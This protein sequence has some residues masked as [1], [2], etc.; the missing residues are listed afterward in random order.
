MLGGVEG[1]DH[2]RLPRDVGGLVD[3][4]LGDRGLV[5][6]GLVDRS[7]G[8]GGCS[9]LR[10]GAHE[11]AQPL[12]ASRAGTLHRS[13]GSTG[14][15]AHRLHRGFRGT[16][17]ALGLGGGGLWRLG[18]LVLA[19]WAAHAIR[20]PLNGYLRGNTRGNQGRGARGVDPR[21]HDPQDFTCRATGGCCRIDRKRV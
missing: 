17:G 1:L 7:L 16:G 20:V 5:G 14:R 3:R 13:P 6:R 9:N 21:G 12:I 18:N 4:N 11:M 8:D 2:L 19:S 10:T 15:P